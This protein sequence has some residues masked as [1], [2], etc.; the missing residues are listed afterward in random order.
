MYVA[1]SRILAEGGH[2]VVRFDFSGVGDSQPRK[3]PLSPVVA[4]LTD[5]GEV[6]D[7]LQE[8]HQLSRVILVGLC[9]GADYAVLYGH[10]DPRVVG[11]VL[12]DPTM[13][14][15]ARYYFHYIVSRLHNVRNWMSV[16]TGKSGLLRL[17]FAHLRN[18]VR[19]QARVEG[20]TLQNLQFSNYLARCYQA[21]A[22]R[23][24]K[25]LSVFTSVS[26]RQTYRRQMLDAFPEACAGGGLRLEFFPDSDHLFSAERERQRLF[27][28]IADWLRPA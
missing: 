19:P 21:T 13:P 10:T 28:V 27:R 4:S 15:T 26:V 22:A 17:V 11:L 2:T 18:R 8:T 7:W 9:S 16:V 5:I 24:I 3:D 12:M 20:L 23:G 1:L 6:L 14:P 25:M